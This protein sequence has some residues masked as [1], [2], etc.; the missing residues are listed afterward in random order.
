MSAPDRDDLEHRL[1]ELF[2]HRAATVTQVR[3]FDLGTAGRRRAVRR[4]VAVDHPRWRPVGVLAAAVALFLAVAGTILAIQGSRPRPAPPVGTPTPTPTT[5]AASCLAPASWRQAIAAGAF[6]VTDPFN[7]VVS[8]N[9]GTGDYLALQGKQPSADHQSQIYAGLKAV[10]YHGT[11]ASTVYTSQNPDDFIQADPTGAISAGW[12][13]FAVARPQGGDNVYQVMLYERST[14]TVRTLA[15][16]AAQAKLGQKR[17]TTPPVIAAGKVYWLA[18]VG[19]RPGTATL[20]SWDLSRNATAG[21]AAVPG[22]TG[23]VGYGSG[24]AVFHASGTIETSPGLSNGA[25]APLSKA[26]LAATAAGANYGSDGTGK[27]SWLR[28]DGK[29]VRYAEFVV[30]GAGVTYQP[31]TTQSPGIRPA[32]FPF[33][34]VALPDDTDAL[35]P[36]RAV[37]DLRTGKAVALPDGISFGVVVGDSVV[38]GTGEHSSGGASGAAGLSVVPV[39]SLPP[40][41]C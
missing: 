4:L 11:Q 27:L 10:L 28:Y 40:V 25:G 22:F 14:G 21:S 16:A 32:V 29:S 6:A 36:T 38:F 37:L 34:D 9:G 35:N 23:L 3:Q 5:S 19:N 17:V 13:A 39:S 12:V 20:E 2:Q 41:R 8:A 33:T 7:A 31:Y 26:Q 15:G 24:V 1:T 18:E 30:G